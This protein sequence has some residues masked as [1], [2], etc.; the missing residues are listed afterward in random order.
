[1]AGL[2]GGGDQIQNS[3]GLPASVAL[4]LQGAILFFVLGGDLFTQ[5]RVRL[6]RRGQE[7][8]EAR[9]AVEPGT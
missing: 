5:Y 3:M 8:E 6:V 9:P 4:V 2:L 1:M 7:A